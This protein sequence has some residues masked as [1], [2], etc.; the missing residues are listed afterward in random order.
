[1]A[2]HTVWRESALPIRRQRRRRD[3]RRGRKSGASP[4]PQR[5]GVGGSIRA[6]SAPRAALTAKLPREALALLFGVD[7]SACGGGYWPLT[8]VHSDPLWV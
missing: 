3:K 8:T 7:L 4:A 2:D 1:M 6:P 5:K